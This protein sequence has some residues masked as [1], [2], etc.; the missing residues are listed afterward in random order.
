MFYGS[1]LCLYGKWQFEVMEDYEAALKCVDEGL[2]L[3][4][5]GEAGWL[6]KFGEE[7]VFYQEELGELNVSE[8]IKK[9]PGGLENG[10]EIETIDSGEIETFITNYRDKCKPV[11]I[12]DVVN[13]WPAFKKWTL[14]YLYKKIG[15]RRVPIEIGSKYT[16]DSWYQRIMPFKEFISTGMKG[17]LAQH[18]LLEQI[19]SLKDDIIVPDFAY[20]TNEI[21][22]LEMNV[23]I[24]PAGT[25]SPLHCDPRNNL[26]CQIKGRKFV[27]LVSPNYNHEDELYLFGDMIR[28]NSSAV[29]VLCPDYK[30]HPGFRNVVVEDYVM[31]AGDCLYIPKKYFH[32]V[33]S[34][35]SSVSVS[36]WFD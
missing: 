35:E 14:E 11:I 1:L 36:V 5:D 21:S 2:L 29:D 26:F 10:I 22:Q 31:E 19:P 3:G 13:H 8:K 34:L 28:N 16:D 17:Y 15:H 4:Y 9:I 24:G 25:L 33:Y 18:R 30:T 32:C 6:A 27:R 20:M 12:K 23:F 7:L